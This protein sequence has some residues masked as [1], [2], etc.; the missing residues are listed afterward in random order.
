MVPGVSGVETPEALAATFA[1]AMRTG[2]VES[3]LDLWVEDPTIIV[4]GGQPVHGREAVGGALGAL[5]QNGASLDLQVDRVYTAG[6]VALVL[7]TLTISGTDGDGRDY[8]QRSSSTVIYSRGADGGWR[9]ALDAPWGL[10]V[11]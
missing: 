3:A 10:P 2:D 7:G 11:G 8:S 6:D 4:P 1:A 9:V 5:I